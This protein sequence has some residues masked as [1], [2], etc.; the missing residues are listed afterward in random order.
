MQGTTKD[1]ESCAVKIAAG[2]HHIKKGPIASRMNTRLN[3]PHL[4]LQ[5]VPNMNLQASLHQKVQ[6]QGWPKGSCQCHHKSY[7][8][9]QG[10]HCADRG[11]EAHRSR[12]KGLG[13]AWG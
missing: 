8:H 13:D 1:W 5:K 6:P 10:T 9:W 4:K 11:V 3:K 2:E 12:A 7:G